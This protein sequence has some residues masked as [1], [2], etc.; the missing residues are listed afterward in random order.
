[1]ADHDSPEHRA[2]VEG[3]LV[4]RPRSTHQCHHT[5]L[6]PLDEGLH[7]CCWCGTLLD[8]DV[9][10]PPAKDTNGTSW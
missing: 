4:K 9:A 5:N 3:P 6:V 1:M 10:H 2:P 7:W 8:D